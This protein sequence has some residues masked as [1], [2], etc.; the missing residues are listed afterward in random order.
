M[1]TAPSIPWMEVLADNFL[2]PGG[3]P[4]YQIDTL[5][6]RYPLTLHSVGISI[7]SCEPL[8]F[9]YLKQLKQLKD[10]SG[11]R[12]LSD[13]LCFTHIGG[14]YSHDLLP[15]PYTEEALRHVCQRLGIVQDFFGEAILIENVS[16][17]IDYHESN[18][19]EEE[20]V[21]A[22]V[23]ES[24][25]N[26]L[27]DVNNI[28]VTQVNRGRNPEAYLEQIPWHKVREIHLAGYDNSQG[29][30][31]DAHNNPVSDPVWALFTKVLETLQQ[32]SDTS[33]APIPTMIEW[34]NDI[35]P[36]ATLLK[37]REK[38]DTIRYSVIKDRA[39]SEN[40]HRQA[41]WTCEH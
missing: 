32:L 29:V 40:L 21:R 8:D 4:A 6:E 31:I 25:C 18:M 17:Y 38:A 27:L 36:L 37:E 39:F 16:S 12:W 28:Y 24:N 11:A 26:L 10:R 22:V 33:A 35:P 2:C 19:L 30:L 14:H 7:G 13:H 23:E 9:D 34:D 20:F 1:E 41:S 5:A 15:L 3:M